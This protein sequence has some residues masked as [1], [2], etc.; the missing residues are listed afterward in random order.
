MR[1]YVAEAY[2]SR[3]MIADWV[4]HDTGTGN[5]HVHVMLTLR[6]LE[7]DDW[8]LKNEDWNKRSALHTQ[9]KMWADHANLMLEREGFSERI[10]HRSLKQQELELEPEG[11]N[12]YIAEHAELNG[13][14]PRAKLRC[15]EVRKRNQA[16]LRAHPDHILAVVQAGRSVF[17]E[18]DVRKAFA[19]RLGLALE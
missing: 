16:Y 12:P 14:V 2:T 19:K 5:P 9:R 4:M 15:A 18:A 11:Y 1:G 6:D 3:G 13:E 17:G 10:D 8:G 7:D